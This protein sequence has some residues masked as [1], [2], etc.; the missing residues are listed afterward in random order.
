VKQLIV[1]QRACKF[2]EAQTPHDEN[3]RA[4]GNSIG[5][6]DNQGI[7]IERFLVMRE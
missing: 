4:Q 6:A 1:Y 3:E 7:R 2:V 5:L